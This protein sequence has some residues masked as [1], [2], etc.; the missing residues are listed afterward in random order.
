MLSFSVILYIVFTT[1]LGVA[2]VRFVKNSADFLSAG[3]K[4]PF[5]LSS[6]ALFAFWFGSETV[7]GASS[8]FIQHGLLGVIEDPF[9]GFLCLFLFALVFVRP[10][11]RNNIITLGDLFRKQYGRQVEVMASLFMTLTFFGYIAAQLIALSI[12]LNAVFGL[13]SAAGILTSALVVTLYTVFGGM[14]AVSI[15]DFIQ[16][17]VILTGLVALVIFLSWEVNVIQVFDRA[18]AGHFQ[19]A[20]A[21]GG[22]SDWAD[23]MAAW[24]TL[25]FGSLASQDIFQRANAAKSEKVAVRSTYAGAFMYL[26]FAMLP[27][28]LG[29]LVYHLSPELTLG[30]TQ[31][32]LTSLVKMHAPLWL[33]VLFY[34]ALIS[35]IFSTCSGAL[36]APASILAENLLKPLFIHNADDRRF[37]LLS[38]VSVV[39]VSLVATYLAFGRTSIYDLVAESSIFGLVCIL[40]PMFCALFLKRST[41]L[42]AVLSMVLGLGSYLL[43]AYV[44]PSSFPPMFIGF[45]VS[46]A[47]MALGNW[48]SWR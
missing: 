12:L 32:A 11:Y 2:C 25:G 3:R 19:F 13:P 45:F 22:I 46:I 20:P 9:G 16:S 40:V 24:L 43:G 18:P 34:G 41:S 31:Y 14:W 28:Y 10:L 47:G 33:Q 1:L 39:L 26:L 7:F 48:L 38:R 36:L 4:L 35:A 5:A 42:G 37:L 15:T 30:D 44:V 21:G 27:L 6:F 29:L 23:Y 17:L 8:E